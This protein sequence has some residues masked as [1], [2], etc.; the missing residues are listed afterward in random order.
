MESKKA[1][2]QLAGKL[3]YQMIE[4]TRASIG[5]N[6]INGNKLFS[7]ITLGVGPVNLTFGKGQKLLQ[8]QNN[9]GNIAF[10][11][12]GLSNYA[13]T[14]T[15]SFQFDWANLAPV[16]SE[17]FIKDLY[18]LFPAMGATG[19]HVVFSDQKYALTSSLIAHEMGHI[20]HS[21]ALGDMFIPNY[22][23]QGL[24]PLLMRTDQ[25]Y[26]NYFEKI[27]EYGF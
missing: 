8:W 3:G 19:A 20:W 14:K 15:G 22:F 25:Y 11:T 2:W 18:D 10:N 7:K 16:Y 17:G 13:F 21:R 26:G 5:N 4:K 23:F 6:W 9:L 27:A 1:G 24:F 12:I